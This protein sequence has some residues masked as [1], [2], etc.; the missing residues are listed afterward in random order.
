MLVSN[1]PRPSKLHLDRSAK[2]ANLGC[3]HRTTPD[4]ALNVLDSGW[5]AEPVDAVSLGQGYSSGWGAKEQGSEMCSRDS[6]SWYDSGSK[7]SAI[8]RG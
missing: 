3:F 5:W 1:S 7:L 4:V 8:L 6:E 2:A